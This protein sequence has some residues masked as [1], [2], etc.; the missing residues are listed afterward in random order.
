M[1]WVI[2]SLHRPTAPATK[3]DTDHLAVSVL[4][5]A[6]GH[7]VMKYGVTDWLF[8]RW[9]T[10]RDIRQHSLGGAQTLC[11]HGGR[12]GGAGHAGSLCRHPFCIGTPMLCFVFSGFMAFWLPAENVLGS[13]PNVVSQLYSRSSVKHA[14]LTISV[15]VKAV[16]IY[17]TQ[18]SC[19]WDAVMWTFSPW[20]RTRWLEGSSSSLPQLTWPS[21]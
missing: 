4:L 12:Y 6:P 9:S 21:A 15:K 10:H 14:T 7:V 2:A 19:A 1:L 11:S 16:H 18:L 3:G 20:F 5:S 13:I 8:D 17:L